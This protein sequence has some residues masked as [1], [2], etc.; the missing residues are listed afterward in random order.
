MAARRLVVLPPAAALSQPPFLNVITEGYFP[1]TPREN[2][3]KTEHGVAA[4]ACKRARPG[5]SRSRVHNDV[6]SR[7]G[8]EGKKKKEKQTRERKIRLSHI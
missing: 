1:A 3:G 8:N 5:V 7:G 6:G 4:A 2:D